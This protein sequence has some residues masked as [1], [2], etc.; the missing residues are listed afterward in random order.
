MARGTRRQAGRSI[1]AWASLRPRCR[2]AGGETGMT[3]YEK[4]GVFYLGGAYDAAAKQPTGEPLL[5]DAKGLVTHAVVI[6]MTGSGKTGLGVSLLEEAAIDGVPALVIDPKGDLA[7]LALAFPELRAA[8]FRPWVDESAAE[9]EG[10]TADALAE[11]TA[12]AWRAGLAEWGQDGA[13]IGRFRDAARVAVFTPGSK[14]GIPLALLRSF[15]APAGA[16]GAPAPVRPRRSRGA[17]RPRHR[18]R[19]R[20]AGAGRDRGRRRPRPRR[21]PALGD[22]RGGLGRGAQPR[23]GGAGGRGPEAAVRA[24]G[25][26]PA[27]LVLPRQGPL[28]PGAG[29]EQPAGVAGLRGLA[30]RGAARDPA[31]ALHRRRQAAAGGAVDRA[32]LG[33]RADVLRHAAAQRAGGLDADAARHDQPAR[34]LVHGRSLRLLPA[35]RQPAVEEADADAAQAGPGLRDRRRALDAEPGRPRL[36]GAGQRRDVVRR[37]AADRPR[38]GSRAGRAG[39]R[40]GV[41]REGVRPRRDGRDDGGARQARL[42]AE[43][44]LRGRSGG[45][46]DAVG[47]ELPARAADAGG[48]PA[49][50]RRGAGGERASPP[51]SSAPPQR[52]PRRAPRPAPAPSPRGPRRALPARPGRTRRRSTAPR[53]SAMPARTSSPRSWASTRGA[54]WRTWRRSSP[55]PI[56]TT[57]G[58]GP[59]SCPPRRPPRT[60]RRRTGRASSHPPPTASNRGGW[61]AGARGSA[62]TSTAPRR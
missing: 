9:R 3:D 20:P 30:G 36:Q 43:Q 33:R 11:K 13:R 57:R 39:R 35:G 32:P 24:G 55:G 50:A 4:L 47:A 40:G 15:A 37:A 62:T 23:P 53:C 58:T 26:P 61:R 22:P 16:G 19:R 27:R 10:I 42:P 44:H 25:R 49:V 31:A 8:D 2:D 41:D 12:A 38:P 21:D 34:A 60:R 5:V 6:G 28:R 46:P 52:P 59:R 14:A 54:S 48:D 17:A 1:R 18:D 7:N 51:R 56:S 45:V 29:A